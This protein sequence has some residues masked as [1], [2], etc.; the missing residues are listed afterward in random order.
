MRIVTLDELTDDMKLARDIIDPDTGRVLLG[1]GAA[2]LPRFAARLQGSGIGYVYVRDN[3]AVGLEL[4]PG[5]NEALRAEA[6]RAL[7]AIFEKLQLEQQPEYSTILWIVRD[8]LNE[9]LNIDEFVV[10]VHELRSHGGNF[11]GHSVNVAVLSLLLGQSLGLGHERLRQLGMGALL[12][13]IG[14]TLL[15]PALRD[16][17]GIL[18]EPEQL[19]YQQHVVLGYNLVKESWDVAALARTVILSHHERSDGSGYPRRLLQGDIHE[20]ARIAGLADCFEEL[21]GGHPL[22]P[23]LSVQEAVEMIKIQGPSWY[24]GELVEFLISRIPIYQT[25][26]TVSLADGRKAVVIAQN[27]GFPTR[28]VIRVF[29]AGDGSRIVPGEEVDLLETNHLFIHAL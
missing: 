20:F 1:Q 8:L 14:V 7:R 23:K 17:R 26:T 11:I 21:T 28:P 10:N 27:R 9:V 16:R 2:S 12:H 3:V 19:V 13:D 24:G 25:G 15:P 4:K 18:T 22:S 29:Q 5:L 6:D